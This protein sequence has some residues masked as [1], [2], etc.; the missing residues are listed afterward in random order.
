MS[1]IYDTC[2]GMYERVTKAQDNL[3][4]ILD[5]IEKWGSVPLFARKDMNKDLLLDLTNRE[6]NLNNRLKQCLESKRAIDRVIMD[7]NFRLFFN[8]PFSCP[9]SSDDDDDGDDS[10]SVE[11]DRVSEK[12][13][14]QEESGMISQKAQASFSDDEIAKLRAPIKVNIIKSSAQ[15]QL[16]R[17]YE[18]YVDNLMGKAM[19][20]AV[21]TRCVFSY[22]KSKFIFD[23]TG[24]GE[25]VF[26]FGEGAL[27]AAT[28][29]KEGSRLVKDRYR[30]R[31]VT[32]RVTS[33]QTCRNHISSK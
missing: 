24:N 18:E 28:T 15:L 27:E 13:G 23:I 31:I 9:C 20:D 2:K 33:E 6:T 10:D 21:L 8:I 7:D 29:C 25:S 5:Q 11:K 17:P 30:C 19:M 26:D 22:K 16:Y 4:K 14:H 32:P 3:K 1:K 12:S